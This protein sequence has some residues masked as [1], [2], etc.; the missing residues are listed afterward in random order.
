M[1]IDIRLL[2]ESFKKVFAHGDVFIESFY[3]HLFRLHPETRSV[4]L[5]T[6]RAVFREKLLA[7]L[8][9]IINNL[10]NPELL[11]P[12]LKELGQH[13]R[14]DYKVPPDHFHKGKEALL[15]AFA[16]ILG[17]E[18]SPE[19]RDAWGKAYDETVKMM[20]EGYK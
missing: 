8:M 15:K 4:F 13:H 6:D 20:L 11:A 3:E 18:W 16:Q 1:G 7:S 14:E 12:Y 17:S 9:T 10:K 19:Y 2:E 5:T